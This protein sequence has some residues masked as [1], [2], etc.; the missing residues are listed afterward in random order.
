MTKIVTG[1][2]DQVVNLDHYTVCLDCNDDDDDTFAVKAFC[3]YPPNFG[4]TLLS[5][6][7]HNECRTYLRKLTAL[8]GAYEYKNG[9]FYPVKAGDVDG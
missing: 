9:N 1:D 3:V 6:V 5:G 2:G 7:S 8:A 4:A